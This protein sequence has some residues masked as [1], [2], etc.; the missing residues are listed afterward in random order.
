MTTPLG[1]LVTLAL[2]LLVFSLSR[3]GAAVVLIATVCYMTEGQPL[4][5]AGFHFTAIRFVLLAGLVRVL[6]RSENRTLRFNPIDRALV[7]FAI[8]CLV[9]GTIRVGTLA[10]LVYQVGILYNELLSY[11]LFRALIR[12]T[13][14]FFKVLK[15][16]AYLLVPF[17]L[18]LVVES[19]SHRNFFAVFGGVSEIDMLRDGHVRSQGAFRSPIT[20]GSFGAT[21]GVLFATMIFAGKDRRVAVVGLVASILAMM[22]TH[23][24][25]PL[26]GFALGVLALCCWP[27][28]RHTGLIRWGI[29]V[30]IVGLQ[31]SMKV[32]VWFLLGRISDVVGGGGYHRAYLIDQFVRHF[33]DWWM[34]GTDNTIDWMPTQLDSGGSDLTNKFVSDGVNGGLIGLGLSILLLVRCFRRIGEAMSWSRRMDPS[35]EKL[36]WGLGATLV[37]TIGIFFSVTYFDQTY[38]LWSFLLAAVAAI[39]LPKR[40]ARKLG[41]ASRQSS[42]GDLIPTKENLAPALNAHS[43][44]SV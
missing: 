36:D 40:L 28:R 43:H 5:L 2:T 6:A 1:A 13:R 44:L 12:D 7:Y 18:L 14:D 42:V 37:A 15:Y 10:E 35:M 11:F 8:A 20:A 34:A 32:P 31:L 3:R 39:E 30:A 21:L 16:V 24:S 25:G 38:V 17:A 26:L 33:S 9:I 22:F 19:S 23:S 27:I 41:P 29:V 4:E